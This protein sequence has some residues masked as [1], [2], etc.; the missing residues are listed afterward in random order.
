[1]R[2]AIDFMRRNYVLQI[3]VGIF[4]FMFYVY[5]FDAIAKFN[6]ISPTSYANYM[7]FF[8][9]LVILYYVLPRDRTFI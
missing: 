2:E 9:F 3:L 7:F 4:L 5:V 8:G 1:M 6:N